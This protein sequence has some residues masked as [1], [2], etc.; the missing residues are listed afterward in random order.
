MVLQTVV[1]T[2]TPGLAFAMKGLHH[3]EWTQ[4]DFSRIREEFYP[5]SLESDSQE[6]EDPTSSSDSSPQ[7]SSGGR[8]NG[9][10]QGNRRL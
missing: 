6:A 2:S 5:P 7:T 9:K 10:Q 4:I 3:S 8:G 1:N